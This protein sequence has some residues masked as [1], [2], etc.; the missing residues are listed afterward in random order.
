MP[1][2][3]PI[4]ELDDERL[5]AAGVG[6]V[7]K[8]DDLLDAPVAGNKW[9]KL[10]LNLER[11]RRDGHRTLL[12]FGGA[13]SNHVR[14]V[15]QAGRVSGFRTVGVIRGEPHPTLNPTLAFAQDHGMRIIYLDRERYRRKDTD[16]VLRPLLAVHGPCYVV[17][18]GG[19]NDL[20]V[21]G[22]LDIAQELAAQTQADEVWVPVGTGGTLAGLSAGLEDRAQAVGVSVLKHPG[23]IDDA[24]RLQVA[25]FGRTLPNMRVVNG[26]HFGGY[27]RRTDELD[28]FIGWFQDRH[29]LRLEWVYVAKMLAGLYTELLAGRVE[30][31]RIAAVITG[32]QDDYH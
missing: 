9:R 8:R 31:R 15:A 32:P 13:Y 24:R 6:L 19:S 4:T 1:A 7:L 21:R 20:G 11:A 16:E 18:E 17:P 2:A 27:A 5:R 26:Y 3:S 14:A 29:G 10:R 22:C 12:T 23:L 30:G 28:D 25:T